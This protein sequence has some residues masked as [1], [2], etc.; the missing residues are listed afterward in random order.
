VD[1]TTRRAFLKVAGVAGLALM[2]GCRAET[3]PTG[4]AT[5]PSTSGASSLAT[6]P[7]EI[8]ITPTGEL[9]TQSYSSVPH[10]D[11]ATW[12]FTVDG[13]VDRPLT[14]SYADLASFAKVESLRTLECIGNPVGG[15]LIGNPRWGGFLAQ[16]IW[17]RVGIRPEAVRAK[18]TSADEYQTSVDLRWI[19]QPDVLFVTE[20]NGEALP[21]EHGFPLRI[22]MPGLYGQKMPKWLTR[23]EFIPEV[24]IGYWE[25]RGW[26]DEA[27]VKTNSIIRQPQGLGALPLGG[28]PVFGLAFAG[29]RRITA[30]EVRIDEGDW[31]P[32]QLVQDPSPL[33]WTQWSFEWPAETGTHRI[34]VRATDETGFVQNSEADTLLAGAFPDG[35]D[36]IHSVIVRVEG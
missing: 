8:V 19:T 13:L 11:P 36:E 6:A 33:I 2:T 15:P 26:S 31:Q 18:F 14:L 16:E 34:A 30:V 25:G 5:S 22:L 35:A 4:E 20:I 10:V 1:P 21:A 9:Y 3:P 24:F 28:L 23:I 32:A 29:L 27:S 17:D 12:R 7:I